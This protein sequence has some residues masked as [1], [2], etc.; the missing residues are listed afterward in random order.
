[1]S[2]W[3]PLGKM[4]FKCISKMYFKNH[5]RNLEDQMKV[6]L[7]FSPPLDYTPMYIYQQLL[8]LRYS[9]LSF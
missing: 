8:K 2:F 7:G 3:D 6:S 9:V 1:M 4:Y 5:V